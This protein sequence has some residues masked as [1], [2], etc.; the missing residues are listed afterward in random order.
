MLLP[1]FK[2][3]KITADLADKESSFLCPEHMYFT[4]GSRFQEK[5]Q[6][7]GTQKIESGCAGLEKKDAQA[8]KIF[9]WTVLYI[10]IIKH[11]AA[12]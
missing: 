7:S 9:F 3:K 10:D 4:Y 8:D 2:A 1:W 6:L 11:G 12:A 5:N